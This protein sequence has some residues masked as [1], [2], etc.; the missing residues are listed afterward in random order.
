MT[1]PALEHLRP[2]ARIM[3]ERPSG[4]FPVDA[5]RSIVVYSLRRAHGGRNAHLPM[6]GMDSGPGFLPRNQGKPRPLDDWFPETAEFSPQG[7]FSSGQR[8][9]Q[10]RPSFHDALDV[11]LSRRLRAPAQRG[12]REWERITPGIAT[13]SGCPNRS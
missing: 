2:V 7:H 6:R 12:S 8:G 3:H 10:L 4:R 9:R 13:S 11:D 1:L 5:S